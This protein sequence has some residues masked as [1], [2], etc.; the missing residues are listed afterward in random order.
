MKKLAISAIEKAEAREE[1]ENQ[2]RYA[3]V[4]YDN[5]DDDEEN[6][7]VSIYYDCT[8]NINRN[9]SLRMSVSCLVK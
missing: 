2:L 9:I 4:K 5:F 1:F 6:T 8:V 3:F 7:E